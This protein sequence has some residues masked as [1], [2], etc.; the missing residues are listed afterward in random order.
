V[1]RGRGAAVVVVPWSW[2]CR[3]RGAP[4]VVIGSTVP[5]C[6]GRGHL[7]NGAGAADGGE[8]ASEH[9]SPAPPA[10]AASKPG[11]VPCRCR[12]A[13][14][15][16]CRAAELPSCLPAVLPACLPACLPPSVNP[17][18]D[19]QAT[20]HDASERAGRGRGGA[21]RGLGGGERAQAGA[22]CRHAG[23]HHPSPPTAPPPAAKFVAGVQKIPPHMELI[24][25]KGK[26]GSV[27]L[28]TREERN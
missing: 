14:L 6:R 23:R 28:G 12:A 10:Q 11:G 26:R 5:G 21:G 8:R 18:I 3:G 4:A 2:C 9:A 25:L 16:S 22:A 7:V 17:R 27:E 19:G 13:E 1:R 20:S 15:P 24:L